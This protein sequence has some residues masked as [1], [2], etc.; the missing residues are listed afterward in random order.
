MAATERIFQHLQHHSIVVRVEA[1]QAAAALLVHE[2]AVNLIRPGLEN[3]LKAFLQIMDEIDFEDLV[4][5]LRQI[6]ET[7]SDEVAPYAKSLCIKLSA[8][9]IKLINNKGDADDELTD[10][11]LTATG[12]M[13]AIRKILEA[14]YYIA[15][16]QPQ[17]YPELEEVLE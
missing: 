13:K 7:F 5:S 3:V 10:E 14:V 6:V 16:K 4:N 17:L 8:A 15:D 12:L 2:E 9:F 1:A 11:G